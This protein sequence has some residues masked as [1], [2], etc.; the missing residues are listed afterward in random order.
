MAR[1]WDKYLDAR[2]NIVYSNAG[3]GEKTDIGK[4]PA[5]IIVDVTY[6]FAGDKPEPIESAIESYPTSCG[7]ESWKAIEHIQKLLTAARKM[8]MPIFHTL[9][10]GSKTSSN[11][12]V[13]VK[14]NLFDHPDLLEGGKGTKVVEELKP[15]KGEVVISKKKP[16]AFFGTPLSSYLIAENVD[17]VIVAGCTTSGC[18]RSTVIDAFSYNYKVFVP[19][20]CVFD[21]GITTHAINLFDMQQKYA[22]VVPTA[23]L[24]KELQTVFA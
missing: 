13:P 2:D 17:T 16:S 21:R 1:I 18:I 19:E 23:E 14:G 12:N 20:E 4:R 9:I 6:G 10:E 11:K 8:N 3:F 24:I 15:Q 7:E 22:D 5:L